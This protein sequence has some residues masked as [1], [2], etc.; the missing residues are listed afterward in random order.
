VLVT[1]REHDITAVTEL[2]YQQSLS[3]GINYTRIELDFLVG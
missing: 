1:A 2:D 3:T